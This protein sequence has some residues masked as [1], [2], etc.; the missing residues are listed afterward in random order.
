MQTR[1]CCFT[2]TR[3]KWLKHHTLLLEEKKT[4]QVSEEPLIGQVSAEKQEKEEEKEAVRSVNRAGGPLAPDEDH[5]GPDRHL[6]G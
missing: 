5:Q 1:E 3:Q 4:R 6:L 2:L